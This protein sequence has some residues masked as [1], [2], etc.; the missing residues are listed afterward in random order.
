M[1]GICALITETPE[2]S[3]PL[4][5]CEDTEKRVI[6]LE[7]G[8]PSPMPVTTSHGLAD[9]TQRCLSHRPVP[10]TPTTSTEPGQRLLV[11]AV[12]EPHSGRLARLQGQGAWMHSSTHAPLGTFLSLHHPPARRLFSPLTLW[13][14]GRRKAWEGTGAEKGPST[15]PTYRGGGGS[16]WLGP[17]PQGVL[18]QPH[19]HT[20]LPAPPLWWRGCTGDSS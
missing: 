13:G 4:P 2:R 20:D 10:F 16:R 12:P 9:P 7:A 6:N 1:S 5:S 15:G 14:A 11:E 19:P 3:W 17:R 18:G 8:G